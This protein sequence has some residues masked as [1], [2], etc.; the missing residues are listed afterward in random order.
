[1]LTGKSATGN[2]NICKYIFSIS[3]SAQCQEVTS[4][5]LYAY[6]QLMLSS[7][8]FYF[9]G[10][11]SISYSLR[12]YKATFGNAFVDWGN[13][14]LCS[15]GTCY[16]TY[17]ESIISS[18]S[19]KIYSFSTY[20]NTLTYMYFVTFSTIN[21]NVIGSRY[22]SNNIW[23]GIYGS[24]LNDANIVITASCSP[25]NQLI[26]Y[27]T[28]TSVFIIKQFSSTLYQLTVDPNSGR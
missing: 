2:L 14:I 22:K 7:G 28:Q 10:Y 24:T 9:V 11:D 21:G 1:M 8:T 3:N 20:G 15:T 17:S 12:F 13:K 18:D 6:G 27:D 4:I 23:G 25:F 16:S 19:S 26:V 5:Y